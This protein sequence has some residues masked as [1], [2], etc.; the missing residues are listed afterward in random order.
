MQ[1]TAAGLTSG[2]GRARRCIRKGRRADLRCFCEGSMPRRQRRPLALANETHS[3]H[4]ANVG[5]AQ[6][7]EFAKSVRPDVVVISNGPHPSS[8]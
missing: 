5:A 3:L 6:G 7:V 4:R 2:Q 8:S 1:R